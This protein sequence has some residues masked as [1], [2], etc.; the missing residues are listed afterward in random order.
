[1]NLPNR[2]QVENLPDDVVVECIGVTG[3]SGV[4]PRDT[5]R[6]GSVLG[7]YLRQITTSQELTVDAALSGDRT[8]VIE[9]MLTDQLA[10]HLPYEQ[11]RDHDRRAPGL[12]RSLAPPLRALLTARAAPV[13]EVGR[14]H[15]A[16]GA[17]A[18]TWPGVRPRCRHPSAG[19]SWCPRWCRAPSCSSRSP[20]RARGRDP[21]TPPTRPSRSGRT[22]G[23]P[24]G[25]RRRSMPR[26]SMKPRPHCR[27]SPISTRSG[28]SVCWRS[29]GVELLG[30]ED[31]ELLTRRTGDLAHAGAVETGQGPGVA[32]A[33]GRRYLRRVQPGIVPHPRVRERPAR[34]R[35]RLEQR[36]VRSQVAR[37]LRAGRPGPSRPASGSSSGS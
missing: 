11:R 23:D 29:A 24:R 32:D 25:P 36:A 33:V 10:G 31:A 16:T 27:S 15:G 2:G 34:C 13:P 6:V 8:R 19:S 14:S 21:P 3:A 5:A 37:G 18:F 30:G 1:M 17:A 22:I 9:A 4:R 12:H 20:S 7:E 35:Q 26:L 28:P